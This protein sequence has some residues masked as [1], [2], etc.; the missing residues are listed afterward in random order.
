MKSEAPIA[1]QVFDRVPESLP[2][3]T[4]FTLGAEAPS[5][6]S[7]SHH[8]NHCAEPFGMRV[9]FAMAKQP[10][11]KV[12]HFVLPDGQTDQTIARMTVRSVIE[13]KISGEKRRATKCD[14]KRDDLLIRHALS[15]QL[16]PDLT[17][18]KAPGAEQ[19]A[20]VLDDVLVQNVH[21]EAEANSCACSANASRANRTASAIAARLIPPR[22][23]ST[24]ASQLI[25]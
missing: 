2:G 24:I 7:A 5:G 11:N 23:S 18:G 3:K 8:P 1:K 4:R 15:P 17:D 19:L 21:A 9:E 14:Q 12:R 20:L 25:P 16:V 10:S 6:D 22:H 13:A